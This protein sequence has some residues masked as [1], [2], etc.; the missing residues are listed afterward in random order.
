MPFETWKPRSTLKSVATALTAFRSQKNRH[1]LP[2]DDDDTDSDYHGNQGRR[3]SVTSRHS[4]IDSVKSP[5]GTQEQ[6]PKNQ[7][8]SFYGISKLAKLKNL[9][10]QEHKKTRALTFRTV[11]KAIIGFIR[12]EK[13]LR[14]AI[15]PVKLSQPHKFDLKRLK[16][17]IKRTRAFSAG[18]SKTKQIEIKAPGADN[19]KT[20]KNAFRTAA[21][22][23]SVVKK[24]TSKKGGFIKPS[25]PDTADQAE[26][27][28]S[29]SQSG[30][31]PDNHRGSGYPPGGYGNE[32]DRRYPPGRYDRPTPRGWEP[33]DR[34]GPPRDWYPRD[35]YEYQQGYNM[36]RSGPR[37]EYYRRDMDLDYENRRGPGWVEE[38]L[39]QQ[40]TMDNY[41][42]D[43]DRAPHGERYKLAPPSYG[44]HRNYG[45]DMD[46]S[47]RHS[48]GEDRYLRLFDSSPEDQRRGQSNRD[49]H[50]YYSGPQESREEPRAG[51]GE[52]RI[53]QQERGSKSRKGERPKHRQVND[54]RERSARREHHKSLSP[55]PQ[56]RKGGIE[57]PEEYRWGQ[58][59]MERGQQSRTPRR[60][61][62]MPSRSF[63]QS[64]Y[65]PRHGYPS[66]P[67][68]R[69]EMAKLQ[70]VAVYATAMGGVNDDEGL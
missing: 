44:R 51:F 43:Y 65:H 64:Y 32:W 20:A 6:T 58:G 9:N 27:F 5:H 66:Y 10:L 56:E 7:A 2:Q 53:D 12:Q 22:N 14:L 46:R 4:H 59:G 15:G 17:Y 21:S 38:D 30:F 23:M 55:T 60:G 34:Y 48:P 25:T 11:C 40:D 33:H 42:Q 49:D 18:L 24:L 69:E 52:D 16:N 29:R 3:H 39:D 45:R 47:R 37:D 35:E 54:R 57:T 19:K 26:E 67:N 28:Q 70:S 62:I 13:I 31:I 68:A 8:L 41:R 61:P 1:P 36:Y 50:G 63:D